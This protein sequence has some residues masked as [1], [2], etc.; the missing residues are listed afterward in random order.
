MKKLERGRR[1]FYAVGL[2]EEATM[3]MLAAVARSIT[4]SRSKSRVRPASTER[5]LAPAR[6]MLSIVAHANHRHIEAHIL[7]RLG[8]F[9]DG[10]PP[11]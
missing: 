11:L 4:A 10:E 5:Q 1:E 8:D 7:I 2:R 6:I 9:D 3:A